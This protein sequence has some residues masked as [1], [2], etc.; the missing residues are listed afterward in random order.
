MYLWKRW[1]M[2]K[3]CRFELETHQEFHTGNEL[4]LTLTEMEAIVAKCTDTC[5]ITK[6]STA[7]GPP[8][9][10]QQAS[11]LKLAKFTP[12]G[13]AKHRWALYLCC[14]VLDTFLHCRHN[15]IPFHPQIDKTQASVYG[16]DPTAF[17]AACA[18][19]GSHNVLAAVDS[20]NM[21]P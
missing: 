16:C 21:I 11:S 20:H 3:V 4:L 14:V 2:I 7:T 12:W 15:F 6:C 8:Y 1:A 18:Q 9:F 13:A 5:L 19:G 17:D 10:R